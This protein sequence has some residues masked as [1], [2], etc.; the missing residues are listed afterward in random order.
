METVNCMLWFL[1]IP[2]GILAWMAISPQGFWRTTSAWS[3]RNP[4]ANEPSDAGYMMQ[5]VSA[6]FGL[7]MLL[8]VVI[9]VPQLTRESEES[10]QQQRYEECLSRERATDD[11]EGLL[12]P[13]DWC[14]NLSPTPEGP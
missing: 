12:T 13:E 7:A 8:A 1:L 11:G 9:F 6:I 3:F 4:E 14:E 10:N 5:R 2:A